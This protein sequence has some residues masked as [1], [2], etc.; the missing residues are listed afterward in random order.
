MLFS[1]KWCQIESNLIENRLRRR[2]FRVILRENSDKSVYLQKPDANM[3]PIR[4]FD[5]LVARFRSGAERKRVAVV[6]P[7]DAHTMYVIDRC[8]DEDLAD[9]ALVAVGG[10]LSYFHGLKA[11][12]PERVEILEA[13]DKDEAARIGVGLVH[14]GRADV[15]MKG[16]INTDNLL[17]AVLDK[18]H[19]LLPKGRVMSHVTAVRFLT[20]ACLIL[21]SDA[22]VI[23]APT[24]EQFDAMIRYDIDVCR[25]LGLDEPKVAL[26]HFTEKVNPKFPYTLDYVTLMERAGEGGYG[27]MQLGGPMDVKTACCAESGEIKGISSPVVGTADVLIFPDLTAS[28]TFYKTVSLFGKARM[29]G[30]VTGTSAPVVVPSRADSAESKFYSLALACVAGS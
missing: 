12:F 9:M 4:S 25:R 11:R 6:C 20:T 21:F 22:A 18:E 15:V 2:Y 27:A 1:I 24:L 13:A 8:L 10:D 7:D 28:N 29:A 14:D 19:G 30:M 5:G 17:R 3:E 16:N 23:P 26:I